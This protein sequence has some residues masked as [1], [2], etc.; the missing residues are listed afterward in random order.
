LISE[1]LSLDQS[2]SVIECLYESE[3]SLAPP[4]MTTLV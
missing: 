4:G 3:R 2:I 1:A